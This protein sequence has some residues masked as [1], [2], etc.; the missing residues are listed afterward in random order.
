MPIDHFTLAVPA[1]K[2]DTVVAFYL[3]ALAPLG[4]VKIKDFGRIMGIGA[5]NKPDFWIASRDD[6]TEKQVN[7]YA[8]NA[9]GWWFTR[10]NNAAI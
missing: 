8:F 4:Y 1:S 7:H 6:A 2:Y 9:K 5:D 3:A 10:S